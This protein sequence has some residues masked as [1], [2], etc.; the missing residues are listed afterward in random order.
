MVTFR[1]PFPP[2]VNHYWGNR[3]VVPSR[4]KPFVHTFIGKRGKDYR[5]DVQATVL[6]K[7]GVLQPTSARLRVSIVAVMP[8]RRTRDLS[9]LL[10]AAEDALTHSRVWTDDEQIDRLEVIRGPVKAPG[11]LEVTIERIAEPVQQGQLFGAAK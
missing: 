6:Q 2:S 10:K 1:I 8:D 7:Y 3:V 11:W 5:L 9:N 4:G